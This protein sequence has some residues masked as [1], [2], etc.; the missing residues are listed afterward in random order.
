MRI[1]GVLLVFAA[2]GYPRPAPFGGSDG[3]NGLTDG[4]AGDPPMFLK[5]AQNP[6]YFTA[7]E[8]G[9][10]APTVGGGPVTSW[11]VTPALPP[12]LTLDP[13]TGVISGNPPTGAPLATYT[14]TAANAN[15]MSMVDL[16][17]RVNDVTAIASGT[18]HACAIT[19]GGVVCWGNNQ[20][21]QS[22][23]N[24]ATTG[25]V[26]GTA[27]ATQLCT[28]EQ[29][30]CAIIN[31]ALECWGSNQF[32][33][34]GT[35]SVGGMSAMPQQVIGLPNPVMAV[36]CGQAFTCAIAQSSTWCW[37]DNTHGEIGNGTIS[38]SPATQPVMVSSLQQARAIA[39][40]ST[41]RF[42]CAILMTNQVVCWGDGEGGQIM[43]GVGGDYPTP[44][45]I[46]GLPQG[47]TIQTIG[48]GVAH[49]CA[50][51][52]GT[53][54]CWG[55]NNHGQTGQSIGT[56]FPNPQPVPG[57]TQ[58][59]AVVGGHFHTCMTV[60]SGA[61][62]F[63]FNIQGQLGNGMQSDIPAP[64]GVQG[65]N[66]GVTHIAAGGNDSCSIVNGHVFCWGDG[67]FG[68]L[69]SASTTD[70]SVPVPVTGV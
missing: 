39:I 62:C 69:G 3:S 15:G 47:Q 56:T 45:A 19:A 14:V 20:F 5:Y 33:Q 58:A 51:V 24:A 22:G 63:G 59:I 2:C 16:P 49:A 65:E 44:Q 40:E 60:V 55:E 50:I 27:G 26:P 6:A 7:R 57:V 67:E 70:S 10:D 35:G 8:M 9:S 42:A 43:P 11:T 17:L 32:G 37:G 34:L 64:Q 4:S 48:T 21:G 53:P 52:N 1:V 66:N 68:H 36:A 46:S 25:D 61:V 18:F 54:Y 28:G 13:S 12:G 29:H 30:T 38:P 41:A 23:P 31:G